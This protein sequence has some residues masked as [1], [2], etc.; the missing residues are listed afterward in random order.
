MPAVIKPVP[1][2]ADL[3]HCLSMKVSLSPAKEFL[4]STLIGY[5]GGIHHVQPG[6]LK[7]PKVCRRHQISEP[8]KLKSSLEAKL[9]FLRVIISQLSISGIERLKHFHSESKHAVKIRE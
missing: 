7:F 1:F 4:T 3:F 6:R 5:Q 9:I 8:L 2:T